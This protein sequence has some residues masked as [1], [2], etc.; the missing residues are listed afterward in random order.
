MS[1]TR[2]EMLAACAAAVPASVGGASVVPEGQRSPLGVAEASYSQRLAIDRA[3]GRDA[4][5]SDPLAFLEHCHNLGAGGVQ[6]G[7]GARDKDYAA[8]LRARAAEFGMFV[9]GSV[10]MPRDQSDM[11]RFG[12]E[13]ATAKECG[14]RVL[15][16]V[17]S[18][19]RR[20]EA[21]ATAD[22][23]RRAGERAYQVLTLAEP[24]VA[25]YDLRLAI[26][27]HKDW[28]IAEFHN[29]LKR[30]DS[31]HVGI[32]VDTGNSIAL[33]EDPM[34][35]VEAYAPWVF[36]THLKD[37]AVAEYEEGFLLAEVP[38][39]EGFLDLPR[40][41]GTLRKARPEV[42]FNLEMITRD[43]LKV[44]CLAPRYWVTSA[45][46]PAREL[47]RMLTLVRKQKKPL[48]HVGKLSKEAQTAL[49]EKNV[50]RCLAHAAKNLDLS[51]PKPGP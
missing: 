22:A 12:R 21:Y 30:I 33:L 14:A 25:R 11:E 46:L 41:V 13:V 31:Q 36:S 37:M 51:Q 26:E 29:L 8:R 24:V 38:L 43:P 1:W 39:G 20:Y 18:S 44:P 3:A 16:T 2:R 15:R 9:E 4:G 42:R 34:E 5:L 23:F 7:L 40:M 28:R 32:C 6:I 19:G 10:R 49:E 47:A 35:A 50:R 45:A 48:P 27:N 17:L